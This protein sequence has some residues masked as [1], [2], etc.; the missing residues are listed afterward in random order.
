MLNKL[1]SK[2]NNQ[3]SFL[4]CDKEYDSPELKDLLAW[5]KNGG[6]SFEEKNWYLAGS[7]EITVYEVTKGNITAQLVFETYEGVTL[8]TSSENEHLFSEIRVNT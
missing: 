3:V 6:W 1:F 4:V 8:S 7:Q 5:F 2:G